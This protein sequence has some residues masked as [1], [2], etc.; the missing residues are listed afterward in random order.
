MKQPSS[1][2]TSSGIDPYLKT[3]VEKVAD[4]IAE[5]VN[6][7]TAIDNGSIDT[8][9]S[10][11]TEIAE[12]SGSITQVVQVANIRQHVTMLAND[13]S[14]IDEVANNLGAVN[15]CSNNM[16]TVLLLHSRMADLL[17]ISGSL[18]NIDAV[19]L[20]ED[21][22]NSVYENIPEITTVVSHMG[23]IHYLAENADVI[24]GL[25][26][27]LA[28][29]LTVS[30][31]IDAVITCANN[32]QSIVDSANALAP[33][34]KYCGAHVDPPTTRLDGNALQDGDYYLDTARNS[35]VYYDLEEDFWLHVNPQE[36]IDAKIAAIA[37][38]E[39]AELAEANASDSRAAAEASATEAKSAETQALAHK[40]AANSSAAS[41]ATDAAQAS[42]DASSAATSATNAGVSEGIASTKAS[43]ASL[44]ATQAKTS[45]TN[46][47]SNASVATT[48]ADEASTSADAA[49]V[50]KQGADTAL[51]NATEQADRAEQAALEIENSYVQALTEVAFQVK[52][53]MN[54]RKYAGSGFLE[55]GKHL[56][57]N[58]VS[59]DVVNEG[60]W[61]WLNTPNIIKLGRRADVNSVGVSS[62]DESIVLV[63]GV[64]HKLSRNIFSNDF[65]EI[66]LP[67]AE[68]GTRSYDSATGDVIDYLT[69]TDPKYGDVAD[70][71]NEAS[72]RNFEGEIKGADGRYG[73]QY[74]NSTGDGT[75][76]VTDDVFRSESVGSGGWFSVSQTLTS[77]LTIGDVYELEIE[78]IDANQVFDVRLF[79]ERTSFPAS[80]KG[81][82]KVR[83]VV[84]ATTGGFSVVLN[85]NAAGQYVEYK[86]LRCSKVT[87][88]PILSRQDFGFVETFDQL[89]DE[90]DIVLP[91]GNV[92]YGATT[93]EDGIAT[94]LLTSLGVDQG[95]SAFGEWDT[96]TVGR[97]IR[98][99]TMSDADRKAFLGNGFNN[100]RMTKDG[101]VQRCYRVRVVQG[102]GDEWFVPTPY[103]YIG[104]Y[105]NMQ[106]TNSQATTIVKPR[107]GLEL[108]EDFGV[109][110]VSGGG[111]YASEYS[112]IGWGGLTGED[113]MVF[114]ALGTGGLP[115][116]VVAYN[117]NC[118]A[119]PLFLVQRGNQGA[120]H[121]VYN[122]NGFATLFDV[123]GGNNHSLEWYQTQ[124]KKPSTTYDCFKFE[125]DT[126]N[127]NVPG[128][129]AP[130]V[131]HADGS[132]TQGSSYSGRED[133]YEYY[134]AIYAGQVHD[135]RLSAHKQDTGRLLEDSKRKDVA[136]TKRGKG[137]L[138]FSKY[139]VLGSDAVSS[140]TTG[141]IVFSPDLI[142]NYD[143]TAEDYPNG[144]IVDLPKGSALINGDGETVPILKFQ[145]YSS[146]NIAFYAA[147]DY[148]WTSGNR[149][150]NIRMVFTDKYLTP[151]YDDLPWVDIIGDP[152]RILAT[153]P[154]GVV[155]QWIP[156]INAGGTDTPLNR[157]ANAST[158]RF[159]QTNND[160]VSWSSYTTNV[161][162]AA[163][164]VFAGGGSSMYLTSYPS[165]SDFTEP[166]ATPEA[167]G[168][169]YTVYYTSDYD[170]AYGNRLMPS[171]VGKIGKNIAD[172]FREGESQLLANGRT[173][174][175]SGST[176]LS[177]LSSANPPQHQP[178]NITDVR[179]NSRAVKTLT[180]LTVK[181]GLIYPVYAG[182]EMVFNAIGDWGDTVDA[183]ATT[184]AYG[185]IPVVDNES[186]MTDL[187][188]NTVKTFCHIGLEPLGIADYNESSQS[189]EE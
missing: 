163:N 141:T 158:A 152:E 38:Q 97:G 49:S 80:H 76:T 65:C 57:G 154:N 179:N 82:V 110:Q 24:E 114:K 144:T 20:N 46:S 85:N 6:V 161:D 149:N 73:V 167:Y 41:A 84:T 19:A 143:F 112:N 78:V 165:L 156:Q 111:F 7:S 105:I 68:K 32:I 43:E 35:L 52:R 66:S 77:A 21:N 126:W 127:N 113:A 186:T 58:N 162:T 185:T 12:V 61:S 102:L 39:A 173:G 132:I 62:T 37:A 170:I 25:Y 176:K 29:L 118:F 133:Q 184:N 40:N 104:N 99:S 120:Y 142:V 129:V 148:D 50:S 54:K 64:S 135:L 70:S 30:E 145:R 59:S 89:V 172:V 159:T 28:A 188:G 136:G 95:Y 147:T 34:L 98:W 27:N 130:F 83:E 119:L 134:D 180:H 87:N 92:Q 55:W 101:L 121:P 2:G 67:E 88:Q 106:Y 115:S 168:E 42:S 183:T 177:S 155:G 146:G 125:T 23:D 13:L 150:K 139:A 178:L 10:Q 72:S 5:V 90:Y 53:E 93:D 48:K 15:N 153:F 11:V 116:T 1:I 71:L 157:K 123:G 14:N 69:D 44:S 128:N 4:N 9:N 36:V 103:S 164:T 45:E 181:N 160:G 187:N 138:P 79:G 137:K 174:S 22:I 60:L 33:A 131:W 16:A 63:D 81:V 75:V 182:R 96:T 117:G 151:E 124:A 166:S 94:T 3:D 8:V 169:L 171:L 109:S 122:E 31:D 108:A 47:G 74:L 17:N 26:A 175:G 107:G 56:T 100:V 140:N 86:M 51:V 91:L 189:V 18:D